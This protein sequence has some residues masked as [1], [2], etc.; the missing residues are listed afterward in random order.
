PGWELVTNPLE[1]IEI[2]SRRTTQLAAKRALADL[3]HRKRLT[4]LSPSAQA[5]ASVAKSGDEKKMKWATRIFNLS[6]KQAEA[7]R[8]LAKDYKDRKESPNPLPLNDAMV[9]KELLGHGDVAKIWFGT[10]AIDSKIEEKSDKII[11]GLKEMHK[12]IGA[13]DDMEGKTDTMKEVLRAG[14][15]QGFF[16]EY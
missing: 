13:I 3:L 7:L 12:E 8:R 16:G 2:A 5:L 11:K 6:P 15:Y 10:P 9:A 14:A 1:V 4:L